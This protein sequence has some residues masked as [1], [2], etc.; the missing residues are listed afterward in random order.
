MHT[1]NLQANCILT[2]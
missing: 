2:H 1:K